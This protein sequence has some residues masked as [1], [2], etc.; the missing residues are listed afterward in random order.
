MPT[1]PCT[2][3]TQLC[4]MCWWMQVYITLQRTYLKTVRGRAMLH[5]VGK[6]LIAPGLMVSIELTVCGNED[7]LGLSYNSFGLC[8]MHWQVRSCEGIGVV[9]SIPIK[10]N[11]TAAGCVEEE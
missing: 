2:W 5:Q 6:K 7:N 1:T 4:C 9:G 8:E 3:L 10:G 11:A